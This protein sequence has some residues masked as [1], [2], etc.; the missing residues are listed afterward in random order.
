[1]LFPFLA[2]RRSPERTVLLCSCRKS[3]CLPPIFRSLEKLFDR[4]APLPLDQETIIVGKLAYLSP[5]RKCF[6]GDFPPTRPVRPPAEASLALFRLNLLL[7]FF[8]V[9]VSPYPPELFFFVAF[10]LT[11]FLLKLLPR[12]SLP[13]F[14]FPQRTPPAAVQ[15]MELLFFLCFRFPH[16]AFG[17]VMIFGSPPLFLLR[18]LFFLYDRETV[19][20]NV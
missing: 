18:C 11:A 15:S 13:F 2:C 8:F 14:S 10:M 6:L 17:A 1:M 9:M 16:H 19:A 7:F 4:G 3:P 5:L 12:F 20:S